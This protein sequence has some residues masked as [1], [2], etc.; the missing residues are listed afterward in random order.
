MR[1]VPRRRSPA[2]T[3]SDSTA[4]DTTAARVTE[5][6]SRWHASSRPRMPSSAM[7]HDRPHRP[8]L[9]PE[10]A[11]RQLEREV[12]SGRLDASAVSAVLEA[13]GLVRQR[14]R[15]PAAPAGLSEREVEVLRLVARGLSNREI[16]TRLVV[17]SRTAEHHV[18]HIYAKIG[19]SSRAAAALFAMEH[20]L[21]DVSGHKWADLPMRTLAPRRIVPQHEPP[22]RSPLHSGLH[23]PDPVRAWLLHGCRPRHRDHA[24]LRHRAVR[25]RR[26]RTRPRGRRIRRHDACSFGR[27]PAASRIGTG[28]G[29]S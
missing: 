2:C 8:A 28:A 15:R 23:R 25:I 10:R 19:V 27:S 7:T 26:G 18:Q 14:R 17:S 4:P 6:S 12:E 21:L 5:R 9:A 1:S 29:R 20:G 3:T 11:A 24:V 13:A 22:I 16:A